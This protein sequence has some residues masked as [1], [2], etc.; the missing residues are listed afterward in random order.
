MN[1]E[2]LKY[3]FKGTIFG[4]VVTLIIGGLLIGV[5]SVFVYFK[6]VKKQN[7]LPVMEFINPN[8]SK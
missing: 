5:F 4:V 8:F 2:I 3:Y 7:L 1:V 6:A